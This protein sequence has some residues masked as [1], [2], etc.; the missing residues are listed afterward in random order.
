MYSAAKKAAH[1]KTT[2]IRAE[3][4]RVSCEQGEEIHIGRS[5]KMAEE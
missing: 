3:R 5:F 4:K 1:K 2:L